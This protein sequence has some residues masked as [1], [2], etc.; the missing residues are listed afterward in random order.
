[1]RG[2][3]SLQKLGIKRQERGKVNVYLKERRPIMKRFLIALLVGLIGAVLSASAAYAK[4]RAVKLTLAS[5]YQ[6]TNV[7]VGIQLEEWMGNVRE[8]T[9]GRVSIRGVYGGALLKPTESLDGL[10]NG[11]AD[12]SAF[13]IPYFRGKLPLTSSL[14][15]IID[16]DLGNKLDIYGVMAITDKLYEEFPEFREEWTSLGV[17]PL[18]WLSAVPYPILTKFPVKT[19]EDFKGKKIRIVSSENAALL[20]AIGAVPLSVAWPEIYTSLQTGVISGVY[21]AAD[22]EETAKF[23]E[24]AP[25]LTITGPFLGALNVGAPAVV[26]VNLKSW[27]RISPEDQ[28]A[29]ETVTHDMRTYF[30]W[31]MGKAASDSIEIM[32]ARGTKV[33]RLSNKDFTRWVELSPD[34]YPTAAEKLNKLG[35]PGTK[36]INRF[37]ELAATYISGKWTP[38]QRWYK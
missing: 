10:I 21:T 14:T 16:L 30:A 29:I 13:V 4:P 25:Y 35:L 24:V 1:M 17:K 27:G 6:K 19:L 20:K 38:Y 5:G 32:K 23:D 18:I 28:K 33:S 22:A 2:G 9:N 12:L 34:F 8:A 3:D 37:Q 15:G 31:R 26:A 11:V 7:Q 36:F